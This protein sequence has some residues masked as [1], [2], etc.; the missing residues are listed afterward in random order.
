MSAMETDTAERTEEQQTTT[1]DLQEPTEDS[2]KSLVPVGDQ[3]VA[4]TTTTTEGEP[5][6]EE[7]GTAPKKRL[8]K[9]KKRRP[10]RP[11]VRSCHLPSTILSHS[12]TMP[13]R[14][15]PPTSHL[16]NSLHKPVQSSTSGTTNGLAVTAKTNTSPRTLLKAAATSPATQATPELTPSPVPTSVSSLLEASAHTAKIANTSTVF[17]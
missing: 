1:V 8:V 12:L 6:T 14:S 17:P 4:P 15:I 7:D 5:A 10:A 13:L 2:T 9:K 11:Q 16:A 3:S